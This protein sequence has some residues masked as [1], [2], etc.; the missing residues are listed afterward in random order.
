MAHNFDTTEWD[1]I[2]E[3]VDIIE[4]KLSDIQVQ[5]YFKDEESSKNIDQSDQKCFSD[6][7]NI[8]PNINSGM[9][10]L[11]YEEGL[12]KMHSNDNYESF[13]KPPSDELILSK[14]DPISSFEEVK[15]QRESSDSYD[16]NIL[17]LGSKTV[18]FDPATE[19]IVSTI[20]NEP[21]DLDP[22]PAL[23]HI[24]YNKGM[25]W[26]RSCQAIKNLIAEDPYVRENLTLKRLDMMLERQYNHEVQSE[27]Q[28]EQKEDDLKELDSKID[29]LK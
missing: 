8:H 6:Q 3:Q 19:I 4:D 28:N 16:C 25:A 22:I 9:V 2:N 23:H 11:T 7:E 26:L 13:Q 20:V 24:A 15:Y 21:K 5:D 1:Y 18:Q 10:E 17:K 29:D 12:P 14:T 27:S